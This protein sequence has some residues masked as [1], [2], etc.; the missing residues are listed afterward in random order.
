M[1]PFVNAARGTEPRRSSFWRIASALALLA[2]TAPAV[3]AQDETPTNALFPIAHF[4][5]GAPARIPN[6]R[7]NALGPEYSNVSNFLGQG[8]THGGTA[9]QGGNLITRMIMD[10]ITPTGNN[11]GSD[12]LE[13]TFSVANFNATPVSVRARIRFWFDNGGVPGAYYNLPANVGFTFNPFNFSPGVTLLTG[14]LAPNLFDMPG[15]PFWAG[16]TFDNN[17]GGTGA[18][19]AQM[20][21]MGQG[22]FDPADIGFTDDL[23]FQTTAA[24]SFFP[25]PNPAGTLF[26]GAPNF[27]A[28]FGWEFSVDQP[29]P[30]DKSSWGRV[31][32]LYR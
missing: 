22:I 23:A 10:D 12:V 5:F 13:V 19:L 7:I 16:I 9:N 24:G 21:N 26:S 6:N 11:A 29:V 32:K 31:K 18:T 30:A 14:T 28:S 15:S 20:D 3:Q 17:T 4:D 1:T 27:V 8:L 2:L 25:T